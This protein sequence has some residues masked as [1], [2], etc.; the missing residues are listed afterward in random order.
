MSANVFFIIIPNQRIVV[1]DLIS[2][3]EPNAIYGKIA[4]QRSTHNNYLTLPM[5]FLMISIHYPLVYTS[6]YNWVVA[7]IMFLNWEYQSATFLIHIILEK[8]DLTGLGSL[9][10]FDCYCSFFKHLQ[11]RS[12]ES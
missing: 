10:L 4:K 6:K 2:G 3:K 5:L 11:A 12:L 1:A 9:P 7:L 8:E